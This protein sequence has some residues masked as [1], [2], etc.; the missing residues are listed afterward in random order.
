M[1]ITLNEDLDLVL[2]PEQIE[3]KI[4]ELEMPLKVTLRLTPSQ[5][6]RLQ[7]LCADSN[8]SEDEYL[9]ALVV[10]DLGQR[11][12]RPSINKPTAI[13]NTTLGEPKSVKGYVGGLVRRG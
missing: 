8:Q 13:G 5:R 3:E 12:G 2:D 11:I 1:S 6:N 9:Q 4:A 7:R 10:T